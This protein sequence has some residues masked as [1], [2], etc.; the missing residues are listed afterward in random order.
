MASMKG[1]NDIYHLTYKGVTERFQYFLQDSSR[2]TG[3]TQYGVVISDHRMSSDDESLR[4]RHHELIEQEG[5]FTSKYENIVETIMFSPSHA[6]P[7]LQLTDMVA[8]AVHRA[9]RY[10]EPRFAS[11]IKRSFRTS[12]SGDI[13]GYGLVTMPKADFIEPKGRL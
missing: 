10:G 7:G 11:M 5:S 9:Y 1:Q 8:G 3:Q 13:M 12:P 4:T 6:S 2:I